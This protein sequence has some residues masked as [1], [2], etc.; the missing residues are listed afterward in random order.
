MTLRDRQ[1]THLHGSHPHGEC[2]CI[3]LD[4]DTDKALNRAI[5]H[6]MQHDGTMLFAVLTDI[7]EIEL[8]GQTHIE[9]DRAALPRTSDGVAQVKVDLRAVKRAVSLV[10]NIIQATIVQC[11]LQ[12]IRRHLPHL[13]R[14]HRVLGARRELCLVRQ[15]ERAVD[16][17]EEVNRVLDL[18]LDLIGGHK[19]MR[20]ILR[21]VADAEKP[22]QSTRKLMTMDEAQLGKTQRQITVAVQLGTIDEHAAGAVH[23]LDC[24]V[25]FVDLRGIHI[26]AIVEPMPR[27]LPEL[28]A[29]NH[30]RADLLIAVAAMYL[31]PIVEQCVA[32]CHAVRME[33]REARPLLVQAEEIQFS[34]EFPMVA[35]CRLL[36]HV[37]V[38]I[39]FFL[40]LKR[41]AIDALQHLVLLTAAPVCT[42]DTL[43]LKCL[44]LAGRD[45][46]GACAEVGELA[47]R[48]EGDHLVLGQILNQLHLIV[49]TL[50]TEECNRLCTGNLA[51]DKRQI[52]LDDLLHF[53]F[54]ITKIGIRQ[55]VLHVEIVV[56]AVLDRRSDR[57]LHMALRIQALHRLRHDVRRRMAQ[58]VAA[59]LIIKGQHAQRSILRDRRR[60][61][62]NLA[63][64]ARRECL[65]RQG[66]AHALDDVQYARPCLCLA[67]GAIRQCQLYHKMLSLPNKQKPCPCGIG[68]P[69]SRGQG[70][71][72]HRDFVL[73]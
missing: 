35:L 60:Q 24:I 39:E 48:I 7:G 54:D 12:T 58:S 16:L 11:L 20:I 55:L 69:S 52:L 62:D 68:N 57:E 33:E 2:T 72:K 13:I 43:Q 29:E 22:V 17:V 14:P 64:E 3:V 5:D 66:V 27:G 21:E 26:L 37:Q 61:I 50:L 44:D 25:L 47:L 36:Q 59:A 49:L 10:D 15:S 9:L 45:D 51:A 71:R 30:R 73:P 70:D 63:V 53:L 42:C 46:M 31:A 34:A 28:T 32:Q 67:N 8:L 40:L 56:E 65:F 1:D 4:Q 6:A 19:E 23:R 38:G 18:T 41:R